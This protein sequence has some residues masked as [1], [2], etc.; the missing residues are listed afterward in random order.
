MHIQGHLYY[1]RTVPSA[2]ADV[3]LY[4]ISISLSG[5]A[6][7]AAGVRFST[8]V[9]VQQQKIWHLVL[10]GIS[11]L[12]TTTLLVFEIIPLGMYFVAPAI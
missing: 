11:I 2:R 1:L 5:I 6:L 12:L 9:L 10:F 3:I 4:G 7:V 8:W